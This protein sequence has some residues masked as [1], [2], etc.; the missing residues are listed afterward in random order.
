M[1][2][3]NITTGILSFGMSGQVF[4]SPFIDAHADFDLR[5]IVERSKKIAHQYYPHIISY[6]SVD[7]LLND[8]QIELVIVN[9]PNYLHFEHALAALQAGKH[10][11]VE[12]PATTDRTE[13]LTLQKLAESKG[14]HYMVYQNRRWDTDFNTV[15][16]II[17]SGKLGKIIEVNFRFDRYKPTIGVKT[18]KEKGATAGNGL[19]FDLGPHLLDQVI[20]LF[21]RPIHSHIL[22]SSNRENSLVPDF[23]T[24]QLQFN[25]DITANVTSSLLT[26]NPSPAFII[27]GSKGSFVKTR[28]DIQETQLLNHIQPLDPSY[29]KDPKE[30]AGIL[31][32][33]DS[34]ENPIQEIIES[35]NT[36]YLQLFDAVHSQIRQNIPYPIRP[37]EILWQL[38]LLEQSTYK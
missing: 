8:E 25:N 3:K 38:E 14:L 7:E 21:G 30:Q 36:T 29:G 1:N 2:T 16:N 23:F 24:Y 15:K 12:K 32:T 13:L 10:V 22:T 35:A 20:S 17:E 34:E 28:S 5:G 26:A 19:V 33:F 6:D 11:L 4:H 9:T 37:E 18:F 31:T 27:H